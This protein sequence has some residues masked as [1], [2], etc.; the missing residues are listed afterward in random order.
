MYKV[1]SIDG[2]DYR[3]EYSIEASLYDECIEKIT[4]LMYNIDAANGRDGVRSLIKGISNLPNTAIVC[5]YAGLM[6]YHGV[7]GDGS[8]VTLSTAKKLASALLRNETSDINNWYDLLTMCVDQMGEDGFFDLIGLGSM[9]ESR[10]IPKVP[11]DH[12]RKTKRM[13]KEVSES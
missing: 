3:L 10:R 4:S 2:K 13:P 8:V 1:I 7:E 9:T 5:F 12:K 6:Q 11:Q